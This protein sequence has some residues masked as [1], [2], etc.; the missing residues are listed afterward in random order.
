[1]KYAIAAGSG[2]V[3]SIKFM[4]EGGFTDTQTEWS[5]HKLTFISRHSLLFF[6]LFFKK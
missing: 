2:P 3:M 6:F 5:T 1:M 4:F